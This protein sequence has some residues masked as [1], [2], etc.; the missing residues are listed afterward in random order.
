MKSLFAF[1]FALIANFGL[2]WGSSAMAKPALWMPQGLPETCIRRDTQVFAIDT[3]GSMQKANRFRVL[4]QQ[5]I[6]YLRSQPLNSNQCQQ[7]ILIRF[8]TTADILRDEYLTDSQSR[9]RLITE[10]ST[11]KAN[12]NK[13]NFDE[14]A[15]QIRLVWLQ[16]AQ[17]SVDVPS[18]FTVRVL[19]DGMPD[20]SSGK[21]MFDLAK[22]LDQEFGQQSA[23]NWG[24]IVIPPPGTTPPTA[25]PPKVTGQVYTVTVPLENLPSFLNETAPTI[26]PTISPTISP[27]VQGKSS[28]IPNSPSLSS[29]IWLP[30]AATLG[31]LGTWML[32]RS[33]SSHSETAAPSISVPS[34]VVQSIASLTI[35]EQQEFE[36]GRPVSSRPTEKVLL[37]LGMTAK[38]GSKAG[39]HYLIGDLPQAEILFSITRKPEGNLLLHSH[40][41]Q[42]LFCDGVPLEKDGLEL[43]GNQ[44]FSVKYQQRKW[45]IRPIS[46]HQPSTPRRLS[47][48]TLSPIP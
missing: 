29:L 11:L 42:P 15:K 24:T 26:V 37:P 12:G 9:D 19:T 5:F 47:Q 45:L 33:R 46:E 31:I 25:P 7:V 34:P 14:V 17:R 22:F 4:Q 36:G 43:N 20:P 1:T 39:C 3:S 16:L 27:T 21:P 40:I 10:L 6:R 44:P 32:V 35:I 23:F 2:S 13:T 30:A 8:D 28:K 38:F 48:P 41:S 18:R